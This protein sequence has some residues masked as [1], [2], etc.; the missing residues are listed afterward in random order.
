VEGEVF[1]RELGW[2]NK[3]IGAGYRLGVM[4]LGMEKGWGIRRTGKEMD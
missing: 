3:W 1:G 2:G 4:G